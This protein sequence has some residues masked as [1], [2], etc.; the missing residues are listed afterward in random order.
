MRKYLKK[1]VAAALVCGIMIL[2]SCSSDSSESQQPG[3]LTI[4]TT[5]MT[6][7]VGDTETRVATTNSNATVAYASSDI[8]IATVDNTGKV[9]AVAAGQAI[10]TVSV[11]ETSRFTAAEAQYKVVVKPQPV[12]LINVTNDN[13]GWVIDSLGLAYP[14]GTDG[15]VGRAMIAYVESPGTGLAL[16]LKDAPKNTPSVDH[17]W[18]LAH[19]IGADGNWRMPEMNEFKRIFAAFGGTEYS[20]E[21]LVDSKEFDCGTLRSKLLAAGGDAMSGA[22]WTSTYRVWNGSYTWKWYCHFYSELGRENGSII[23]W[24]ETNRTHGIRPVYYFYVPER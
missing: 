10:I 23:H 14:P 9:T 7:T 4:E 13:L 19:D 15:I 8:S 18:V 16:S 21:E 5:D 24:T 11:A 3:T 22:Y 2:G 17:E 20:E 12:A 6:L 1:G